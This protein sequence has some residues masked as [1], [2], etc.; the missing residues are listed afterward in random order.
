M[1][2]KEIF[3]KLVTKLESLPPE[4]W[5]ESKSGEEHVIYKTNMGRFIVSLCRD[6]VGKIETHVSKYQ[7]IAKEENDDERISFI[8]NQYNSEEYY[9]KRISDL[10]NKVSQKYSKWKKDR[11]KRLEESL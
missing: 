2:E 5:R 8:G 9:Q 10:F 11:I 6:C 3:S 1:E 4:N 7:I